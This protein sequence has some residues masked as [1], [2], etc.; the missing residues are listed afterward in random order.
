MVGECVAR[1]GAWRADLTAT[2]EG[3][4]TVAE[5]RVLV[6][7]RSKTM[8]TGW[9]EFQVN[10]ANPDTIGRSIS[11]L[12]NGAALNEK[13]SAYMVWGVEDSTHDVVGTRFAPSAAR[14]GNESLRGL[15]NR[16]SDSNPR[17]I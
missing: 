13:A 6:R 8:G 14:R 1:W 4:A 15:A 5:G 12:S 9:V 11:A 10:N 2:L 17:P 7:G 3:L 16:A